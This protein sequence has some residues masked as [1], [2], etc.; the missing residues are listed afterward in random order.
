MIPYSAL[1][2]KLERC[3]SV[4]GPL[5][6][7]IRQQHPHRGLWDADTRLPSLEEFIRNTSLSSL[8]LLLS[9]SLCFTLS[10]RPR[11]IFPFL[12][13]SLCFTLSLHL[14]IPFSLYLP[15]AL[16]FTLSLDPGPL[17]LP[18]S[19]CFS[20]PPRPLFLCTTFPSLPLL[21]KQS[22]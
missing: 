19:L 13:A 5:V 7:A 14:P 3:L 18:T 10:R 2:A 15:N 16:C 6:P 8:F 4:C 1:G 21:S 9:T 17:P 20:L 11:T 22:W 12:S